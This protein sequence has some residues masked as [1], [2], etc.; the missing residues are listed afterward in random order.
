MRKE[1]LVIERAD[2]GFK[3]FDR[4]QRTKGIQG[5]RLVK[6]FREDDERSGGRSVSFVGEDQFESTQDASSRDRMALKRDVC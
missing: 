6:C 2:F 3:P 4:E 5:I 1:N